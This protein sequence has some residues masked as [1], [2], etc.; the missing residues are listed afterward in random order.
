ML[1]GYAHLNAGSEAGATA[2]SLDQERMQQAV[3]FKSFT[4]SI[5]TGTPACANAR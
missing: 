4:D 3:Q 2:R 5:D 1:I